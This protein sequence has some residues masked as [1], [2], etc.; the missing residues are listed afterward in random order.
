[1][2]NIV[3]ARLERRRKARRPKSEGG[4]RRVRVTGSIS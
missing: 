2:K 1:V 4:S 3:D